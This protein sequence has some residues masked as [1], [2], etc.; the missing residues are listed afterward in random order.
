LKVNSANDGG[1]RQRVSDGINTAVSLARRF[2]FLKASFLIFCSYSIVSQK[3]THL[4]DERNLLDRPGSDAAFGRKQSRQ[5]TSEGVALDIV[6][7]IVGALIV[8]WLFNAMGTISVTGF[9]LRAFLSPLSDPVMLLIVW[10]AIVQALPS[11]TASGNT[12]S[13]VLPVDEFIP[14]QPN[15]Q[16]HAAMT[17]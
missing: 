12:S 5:R 15:L 9:N 16:S 10:Y 8:G 11:R 7:G 6:P 13:R 1:I 4:G 3:E 2:F 14:N 17:T